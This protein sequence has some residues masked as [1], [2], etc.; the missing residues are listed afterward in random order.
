MPFGV[1][2]YGYVGMLNILMYKPMGNMKKYQQGMPISNTKEKENF[3]IPA[4]H[5]HLKYSRKKNFKRTHSRGLKA[6]IEP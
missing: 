3:Q 5:A 1:C 4:R 2:M 6:Q